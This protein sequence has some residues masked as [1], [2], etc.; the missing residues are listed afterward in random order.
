MKTVLIYLYKTLFVVFIFVLIT[1]LAFLKQDDLIFDNSDVPGKDLIQ[2][3]IVGDAPYDTLGSTALL[4]RF[5]SHIN[6]NNKRSYA[7]FLIHVGDIKKG[8]TPCELSYY[9]NTLKVLE[10][11]SKKPYL[12]IGDNEWNDCG[13]GTD[14]TIG[15]EHWESTFTDL[16]E[17]FINDF[18]ASSQ[19][20]RPE[21]I[22]FLRNSVLF[23][24]INQ[25]DGRIH[26]ST[27][28]RNRMSD[29]LIW[30]QERMTQYK[31]M[32]N[33]YVIFAHAAP[34]IKREKKV[35]G[36]SL[37][38]L[39]FRDLIQTFSE[40]IL[41]IQGNKHVWNY[42][43]TYFGELQPDNFLRVV[44]DE[45]K[46]TQSV[47]QVVVS[48]DRNHPFY[49]DRNMMSDSLSADPSLTLL[50]GSSVAISWQTNQPTSS[51]VRYGKL[52]DS[53]QYRKED[54]AE[55]TNHQITITNLDKATN[56]QFEVGTRTSR[57]SER[58]T[59]ADE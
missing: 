35:I 19:P 46:L 44:I 9:T 49:F 23:L 32:V 25:V 30:A 21:N 51:V 3:A 37:F 45:D 29:N 17:R 15:L 33:A 53:L 54:L 6:D 2:F 10:S 24:T 47:L 56:Y 22:S 7:D 58:L 8:S 14:P 57:L 13:H 26:D 41:Y 28:W 11:S 27:E 43:T 50:D 20:G 48:S 31:G 52:N 42:D 16:N 39:P 12:L 1:N 4:E 38:Y 40:P 5:Q 36:D 55:K 59:I 18:D 34:G